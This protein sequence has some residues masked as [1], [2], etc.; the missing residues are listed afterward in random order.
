MPISGYGLAACTVGFVNIKEE[1]DLLGGIKIISNKPTYLPGA[2]IPLK[3]DSNI[4]VWSVIAN[5]Y[6][7]NQE[8]IEETEL[9][10]QDELI[11]KPELLFND[12]SLQEFGNSETIIIRLQNKSKL[13]SCL[14]RLLERMYRIS[15]FSAIV[16]KVFSSG[17]D[18][19][20]FFVPFSIKATCD[21]L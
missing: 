20:P 7:D 6:D 11:Y 4:K 21:W 15:I 19:P 18:I 5:D 1:E 10:T 3:V 13:F 14:N 16:L 8:L 2:S 12:V 17:L 9:L